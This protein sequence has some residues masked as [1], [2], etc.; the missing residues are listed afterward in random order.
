MI[1]KRVGPFSLAKILG[2]IYAVFGFIVGIFFSFFVLMGMVLGSVIKDSPEPIV[3][4][5]LGFGSVVAFPIF[6]GIIGFIAG[7]ITAGIYN[8][9]SRWVGGIEVDLEEKPAA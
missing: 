3:G 8:I 1:I 5:I 9:I 7:L 2:I 6:Y 4:V